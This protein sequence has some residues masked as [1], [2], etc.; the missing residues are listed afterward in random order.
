MEYR[1]AYTEKL[2]GEKNL[3]LL[4][5]KESICRWFV[6]YTFSSNL[7]NEEKFGLCDLEM[8]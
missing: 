1:V 5:E 7:W 2:G 8:G 4:T 3:C 6:I